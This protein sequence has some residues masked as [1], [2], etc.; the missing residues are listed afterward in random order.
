[1]KRWR[2][3][4]LQPAGLCDA[5]AW[6]R[7]ELAAQ[8]PLGLFSPLPRPSLPSPPHSST[9]AMGALMSISPTGS[10]QAGI[11]KTLCQTAKYMCGLLT[12]RVVYLPEVCA[13]G[14]KQCSGRCGTR[15][16]EEARCG[17][18]LAEA[19]EL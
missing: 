19:L 8:H 7:R 3:E 6:A 12:E 2:R 11:R 15:Q 17:T 9:R 5:A 10:A 13:R 18:R 1:V 16:L 4:G 14:C